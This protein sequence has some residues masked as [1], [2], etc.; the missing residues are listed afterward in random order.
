M[1]LAHVMTD[2][3][4]SRIMDAAIK[5]FFPIKGVVT[6]YMYHHVT[7]AL[8]Q[9]S[10]YSEAVSL[11]R[12][13]WGKMIE[14]GADTYWEA[15]DPDNPEFSPYGSAMVN[16]WCHAWSCSPVYLIHKYMTDQAV[17]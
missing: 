8:F 13:Y 17:Q 11:M 3:E 9:S 4:N 15:F 10:H 2:E 5:E 12:S 14:L 6:P 16:S 7:E 1:I